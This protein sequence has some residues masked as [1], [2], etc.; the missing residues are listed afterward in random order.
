M[1]GFAHVDTVFLRRLYIVV[2]M[3][4]AV[5]TVAVVVASVVSGWRWGALVSPSVWRRRAMAASRRFR[6]DAGSVRRTD[7]RRL[8][9]VP[10]DLGL[11]SESPARVLGGQ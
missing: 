5:V 2:V 7:H 11:H 8:A 9:G 1:L 4:I 6:Q 10:G 3:S